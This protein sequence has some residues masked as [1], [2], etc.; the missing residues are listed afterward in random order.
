MTV[1]AP[2][3]IGAVRFRD[4][5]TVEGS[6]RSLRSRPWTD[7][8]A[9]LE[10]TIVDGTGGIEVVFLGRRRIAGIE[11]GSRLRAHG[12]VGAH[13]QRLSILNPEYELRLD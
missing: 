3:P 2:G 10:C 11:L 9:S 6:V 4:L 8:V 5:T 12:R 13:H 1:G 7:G